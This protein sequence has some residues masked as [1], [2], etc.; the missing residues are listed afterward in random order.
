[1]AYLRSIVYDNLIMKWLYFYQWNNFS[2][3]EYPTLTICIK[4]KALQHTFWDYHES[5]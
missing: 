3:R 5:L 2:N 4:N 1:M